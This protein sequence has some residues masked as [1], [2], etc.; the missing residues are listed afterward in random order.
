MQNQAVH[1]C[2]RFIDIYISAP[3][4]RF[5]SIVSYVISN[6]LGLW[7]PCGSQLHDQLCYEAELAHKYFEENNLEKASLHYGR[8]HILGSHFVQWHATSHWGH[9]KLD[10]MRGSSTRFKIRQ[11]LRL[12]GTIG[13]RLFVPFFGITGHPGDSSISVGAHVPIQDLHLCELLRSELYLD[14]WWIYNILLWM[15][16]WQD[17]E[18]SQVLINDFKI[19][20]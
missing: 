14:R 9:W 3:L 10:T 20:P 17:L 7:V 11:T 8:V 4:F 19:N 16:Y 5:H 12:V 6:V 18:F 2:I 13:T 1:W 15:R